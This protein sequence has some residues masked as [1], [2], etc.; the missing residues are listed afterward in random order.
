MPPESQC[1]G[2]AAGR[3]G[4]EGWPGR[5]TALPCSLHTECTP[6]PALQSALC[7][8]IFKACVAGLN[9]SYVNK[10]NKN[11]A[12]IKVFMNLNCLK[13]QGLR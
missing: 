2:H 4:Q 3:E 7:G 8:N 12:G 13:L 11:R 6:S 5:G 9:S 1:L 10:N